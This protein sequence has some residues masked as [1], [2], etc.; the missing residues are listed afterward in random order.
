M[1]N[2]T[3]RIRPIVSR[4][5]LERLTDTAVLIEPFIF[6]FFYK[7]F[8]RPNFLLLYPFTLTWNYVLRLL[9]NPYAGKLRNFHQLGSDKSGVCCVACCLLVQRVFNKVGDQPFCFICWQFLDET[10]ETR[11]K[12]CLRFFLYSGGAMLTLSPVSQTAIL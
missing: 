9:I 8:P 12:N 11:E 7:K 5:T 4:M 6:R 10:S 3:C 2:I 1:H